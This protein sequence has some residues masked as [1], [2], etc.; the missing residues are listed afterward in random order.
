MV[1]AG[2]CKRPIAILTEFLTLPAIFVME[3]EGYC[4][5]QPWRQK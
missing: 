1:I 4:G 3:L 5:R 2:R